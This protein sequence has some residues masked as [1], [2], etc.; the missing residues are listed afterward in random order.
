VV[1]AVKYNNCPCL[2]IDNLWHALYSTFNLAQNHQID[3]DILKKI[4]DKPSKCWLFFS[5]EEFIKSITKCNNLFAPGPD[6][7]S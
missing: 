7:L 3:V 4:P 6:K 1:E 2:E 5:K